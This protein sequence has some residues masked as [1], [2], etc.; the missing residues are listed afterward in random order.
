MSPAIFTVSGVFSSRDVMAH[1]WALHKWLS[2]RHKQNH[3]LY[4]AIQHNFAIGAYFRDTN[5][6]CSWM[7][8]TSRGLIGRIY[9]KPNHRGKGLAS[10]LVGSMINNCIDHEIPIY[11]TTGIGKHF[12][13]RFDFQIF[14][15]YT[16]VCYDGFPVYDDPIYPRNENLWSIL[17]LRL[18]NISNIK[19]KSSPLCQWPGR[20]LKPNRHPHWLF[21]L[22]AI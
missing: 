12:L 2:S 13:E 16:L 20:R 21:K 15:R 10:S 14:G 5:E 8:I 18:E 19:L 11:A 17:Y 22:K 3:S 7:M 9:T 6:L 1:S 4:F